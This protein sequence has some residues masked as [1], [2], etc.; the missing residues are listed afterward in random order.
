MITLV[1]GW[2]FEP[3]RSNFVA[4]ADHDPFMAYWAEGTI[5]HPITGEL[6]N[7]RLLFTANAFGSP[8]VLTDHDD[9]T[10]CPSGPVS[11]AGVR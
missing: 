8:G 4:P 3:E 10:C 2:N 7:G 9:G 5:E 11:L 1:D 6:L